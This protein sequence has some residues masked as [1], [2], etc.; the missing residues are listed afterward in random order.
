MDLRTKTSSHELTLHATTNTLNG[1]I[2]KVAI[3]ERD[4]SESNAN[5]INFSK[6]IESIKSLKTKV[7][8]VE[9]KARTT[10]NYL[11]KYLPIF[12]QSQIS[13]SLHHCLPST[14][15]RKL[16]VFE[17]KR[18][19]DMNNEVLQDDGNPDLQKRM[20]SMYTI[21]ETTVK[22]Y[23]RSMAANTLGIK[24]RDSEMKQ[25][26]SSASRI[27]R[28][29]K[30]TINNDVRTTE[31]NRYLASD[32]EKYEIAIKHEDKSNRGKKE[33]DLVPTNQDDI[34]ATS[35][36]RGSVRLLKKERLTFKGEFRDRKKRE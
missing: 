20:Q 16:S 2:S 29:G 36:R 32:G 6:H 17:E 31:R 5:I 8:T 11:E 15:K 10:E 12:T 28:T 25:T 18:F 34:D 23:A 9:I 22:R 3:F 4:V 26:E 21:L 13:E 1:I 35:S 27:I 14:N 19:R 30:T 24:A 7:E 33:G